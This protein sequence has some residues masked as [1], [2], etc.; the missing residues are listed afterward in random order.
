MGNKPLHE[1]YDFAVG[2]SVGGIILL[3]HL[4]C[5]CDLKKS[6]PLLIKHFTEY[7]RKSSWLRLLM[8]GSTETVENVEVFLRS[9]GAAYNPKFET[10][11]F[12]ENS[13]SK[14]FPCCV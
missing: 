13:T 1:L 8:T 9:V 11:L 6:L 5:G 10:Q 2:T 7:N 12:D 3:L 4:Y 14:F